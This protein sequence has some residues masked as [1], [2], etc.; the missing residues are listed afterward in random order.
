MD[1]TGLHCALKVWAGKAKFQLLVKP[2]PKIPLAMGLDRLL[3][4]FISMRAGVS[5]LYFSGRLRLALSPLVNHVPVVGALKV[6]RLVIHCRRLC[7]VV[8]RHGRLPACCWTCHMT[9]KSSASGDS[10][11]CLMHC[12]VALELRG[13]MLAHAACQ[14]AIA[15]GHILP[16]SIKAA[17]CS[18]R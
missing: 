11:A 17:L 6:S 15:R 1:L 5:D 4:T 16:H 9:T 12:T 3:S 14:A 7:S 8:S 18:V 13:R 2:L 10:I